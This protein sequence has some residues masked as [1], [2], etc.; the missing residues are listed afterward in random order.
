MAYIRPGVSTSTGGAVPGAGTVTGLVIALA[1]SAPQGPSAPKLVTNKVDGLA[2]YGDDMFYNDFQGWTIPEALRIIYENDFGLTPQVLVCRAGVTQAAILLPNGGATTGAWTATA[3]PSGLGG[4]SG[5]GITLQYATTGG[6]TFTI[7]PPVTAP[8]SV[9]A[10]VYTNLGATATWQQ[11]ANVVNAR[12]ALVNL[13]VAGADGPA[14]A[15]IT[16]ATTTGGADG[17]NA[18][19]AQINATVDA[20]M[21]ITYGQQPIH[22]IVPL[23]PDTA[24][25]GVTLHALTDAVTMLGNGSYQRAQV[26]GAAASGLTVA[27][28]TT[29]ASGLVPT[30]NG[31]DSG[32]CTFFANGMPWRTDPATGLSRQYPGWLLAAAY[33]GACASLPP[34]TPKGRLKLA[35][36]DRVADNFL[37][38]D[39]NSLLAAGLQ[40]IQ[41]TGRLIDQVTTAVASSY[42][43][44]QSVQAQEDTWT[45]M[46]QWY[47]NNVAIE[48]AAGTQ[49][50]QYLDQL[51]GLNLLGYAEQNLMQSSTHN[52]HMSTT[53]ARS[54]EVDV[55]WVPLLPLRNV[56]LRTYLANPPA[57]V[58][59][60]IATF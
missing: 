6:G 24:T 34:S 33:A 46:L 14:T 53:D 57:A 31:G 22:I 20:L 41:Q 36:I 26:F 16:L 43:R 42:R 44:E 4:T 27:A 25:S 5:N 18:T 54:W 59:T 29:L 40:A 47:I 2:I 50:G 51:V 13:T 49:G 1:G 11:I 8:A 15:G 9:N 32:R 10:E 48:T 38:S 52:T 45:G 56:T 60:A 28:L 30:E 37:F 23:F 17:A 39:Q 19:A 35:G 58:A 21:Q 12:S 3:L 55:S 7:T